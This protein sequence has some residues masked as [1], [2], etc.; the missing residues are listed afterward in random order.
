MKLWLLR[1]INEDAVPWIPWTDRCFG[2]VIRTTTE[3]KA[4]K[5]ADENHGDENRYAEKPWLN[6]ELTSC[7]PLTIMGEEEIIIKDFA[8]A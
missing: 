6:K 2:F 5:I 3:E 8:S 4:R 7:K 1:P